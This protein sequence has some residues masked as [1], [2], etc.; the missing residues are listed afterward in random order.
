M[1]CRSFFHTSPM[2]ANRFLVI[3]LVLLAAMT[4]ATADAMEKNLH[5]EWSYDTTLP[6]LAGYKIYQDGALVQTVSNPALLATDV[7][8]TITADT[9]FTMTAFDTDNVES[10]QSAPYLVKYSEVNA[11]PQAASINITLNEDASHTG[12]LS[13][14]DSDNDPLTYSIAGEPTH[15]TLTL[16]NPQTGAFT[17]TPEAN[18]NGTDSFLFKASDG[19]AESNIA[20]VTLAVAPVNDAPITSPIT[21]TADEDTTVSGTLAGADI[22]GD[23]LTFAMVAAPKSGQLAMDPATGS[24]TYTP[25]ADFSG[26][27]TFTFKANDGAVDSATATVQLTIREINDPPVAVVTSLSGKAAPGSTVTLD[28]SASKDIDDGIAAIAWKQ[29]SGPAV[30]LSGA[31]TLTPSFTVPAD[32]PRGTPMAFELTVTDKGGLASASGTSIAVSW[33]LPTPSIK[34]LAAN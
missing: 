10:P 32:G 4:A 20:T 28:G 16:D 22:D 27:D 14:T 17:Y 15:G 7:T 1:Y 9:S 3:L 25:N 13:A 33:R 26:A 6:G 19:W 12:A 30:T 21:L 2:F 29:V 8:I 23:A 5:I 24:F 18:F 11:A 31:N 34:I